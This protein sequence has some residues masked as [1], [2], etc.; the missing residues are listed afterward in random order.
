V[1]SLDS[2]EKQ[3]PNPEAGIM[4]IPILIEPIENG[5]FRARA[6]E[7]FGLSAVGETAQEATQLLAQIIAQRLQNGVQ[8][9]RLQIPSQTPAAPVPIPADN[10]YQ[11]DWVYRELQEAMAE[12]RQLEDS[13]DT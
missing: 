5:R 6:G 12:N 4:D 13:G 11:T 7:P 10:L 9:A 8:L 2:Y 3:R 1:A